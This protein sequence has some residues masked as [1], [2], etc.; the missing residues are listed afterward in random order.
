MLAL[1]IGANTAIFSV[2]NAVLLKPLPF[3]NPNR[4]VMVWEDLSF[5]GF[6]QNTPAPANFV[7]WKKRNHVFE[8]ILRI[9][10]ILLDAAG[11]QEARRTSRHPPIAN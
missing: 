1:S 11:E 4:L 3:R 9:E 5:M 2:V 10:W 6:P 7:D 8:D